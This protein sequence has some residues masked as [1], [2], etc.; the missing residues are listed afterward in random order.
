M[1]VTTKM[2]EEGV[3]IVIP[4]ATA[5]AAGLSESQFLDISVEAGAIVVHRPGQ[6]RR[7]FR[8][9]LSEIVSQIEPEAY[10]KQREAFRGWL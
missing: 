6:R 10:Q 3:A 5:T 4:Q 7:R 8:R 9:P 2:T 1:I